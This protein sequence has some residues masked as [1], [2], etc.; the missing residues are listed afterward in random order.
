MYRHGVSTGEQGT[1]VVTPLKGGNLL[2][3][4]G[5]A[6]IN[7]A[8][9]KNVNKAIL[10]TSKKDGVKALGYSNNFKD[11]TLCETMY[12]AF[13]LYSVAPVIFINVL[14]PLKHKV[15]VA[16]EAYT[17]NSEQLVIEIEG[18]LKNTVAIAPTTGNDF[19]EGIDYIL[20]FNDNGHLI[21]NVL[22]ASMSGDILL[23]YNRLDP[24]MV[25]KQDIIGGV[26]IEGKNEG[27]E[28]IEDIFS[29]YTLV[30]NIAIA[31]GWSHDSEVGAVLKAKISNVNTVFKG[32]AC[33]DLD[34]KTAK[35]Y[36]Q[37]L[38]EKK[39][40]NFVSENQTVNWPMCKLGDKIMHL[41]THQA[42]LIMQVDVNNGGYA[43][44]SPSNKGYQMDGL[45]LED[46]TEVILT[47]PQANIL[48]GNGICTALN[49]I[50]GWKSWGNRTGCYPGNSDAKDAFIPV[51]R[52]FLQEANELV[53]TFWQKVDKPG[54]RRLIETIINSENIKLNGLTNMGVILGGR[55]EFLEAEN[56]ITNLLNGH[57]TFHI[58]MTPPTPAKELEF[59]LELDVSYFN[60][61][62]G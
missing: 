36:P 43:Y 25:T 57:Y 51:K 49:F 23:S 13:D 34:T 19:V 28:V 16:N 42:C 54:N 2:V 8:D 24:S 61:L 29:L 9:P 22:N 56:P 5:T 45:C 11:Y 6:P 1:S 48:N 55:V 26:T 39:S 38:T 30:P 33:L 52:M 53:L 21:V 15:T 7:L 35:Q 59:I 27:L 46:G 37:A 41:S 32:I 31:P 12:T 47:K 20:D 14:D 62:F 4:V 58:Y 40:V 50:G 3:V 60:T 10:A 44:E 18:I 17:L